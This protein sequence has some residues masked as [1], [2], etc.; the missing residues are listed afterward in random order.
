MSEEE[1]SRRLTE[2]AQAVS[3]G[4]DYIHYKGKLYTVRDLAILESTNE[5]CVIYQAQYGNRLTFI[6]PVSD[7]IKDVQWQGETL[8][9]F[10]KI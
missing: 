4:A 1:L 7:W 9:R 2:A 8:T 5:I 10:T 3:V 6:R